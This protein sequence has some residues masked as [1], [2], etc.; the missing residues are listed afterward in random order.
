MHA[1]AYSEQASDAAHVTTSAGD[2]GAAD[3]P[4]PGAPVPAQNKTTPTDSDVSTQSPA[5]AIDLVDDVATCP[6]SREATL[7]LLG[8][9]ELGAS[10]SAGDPA[11]ARSEGAS[12]GDPSGARS[13]ARRSVS[14]DETSLCAKRG[15]AGRT[16]GSISVDITASETSFIPEASPHIAMRTGILQVLG[17]VQV[18]I[19]RRISALHSLQFRE[20]ASAAITSDRVVTPKIA[21]LN[22]LVLR[23]PTAVL[24]HTAPPASH[25][26]PLCLSPRSLSSVDSPLSPLQNCLA[27]GGSW[28]DDSPTIPKASPKGAATAM[29]PSR[30]DLT[31][32]PM[33]KA[34]NASA[35]AAATAEDAA[36]DGGETGD[37]ANKF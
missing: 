10:A 9:A 19:P 32:S 2:V 24:R 13:E 14:F 23:H 36:V 26:A 16:G 17:G 33:R 28:F 27:E 6:P 8:K 7:T 1:Q 11:E 3:P 4:A 29:P 31:P 20:E 15:R 12:A 25:S 22:R 21:A 34:A 18:Q 35:A 30:L 5:A 37:G